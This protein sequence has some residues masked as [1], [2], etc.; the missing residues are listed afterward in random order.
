M[1][2]NSEEKIINLSSP[3]TDIKGVGP[4]KKES[5]NRLGINCL[6]D[7]L[8]LYP[9][10][11]EDLRNVKEIF[12]VQDDEKCLVRAA[13][14]MSRP[15]KGYG[16]K[17]TLHVLAEDRTGR[18]EVLFF[19]AGFMKFEIGTIYNFFGKCKV[20]NGRVT[21]FHP[22]YSKYEGEEGSILPVYPLTKGLTQ[23]DVR[24]LSKECFNHIDE[25]KETLPEEVVKEANLCSNSYALSNIHYPEDDEKYKQA[26]YRLVF[27]ELF[28]LKTALAISKSMATDDKKGFS[29]TGSF[30]KDFVNKLPYKLT[31]AQ[32]KVLADVLL[33]MK[34]KKPMNRL[35]QGD[36]GSGKTIIAEAAIVQAVLNGAQAAFMAPTEILASQHFETLKKDFEKLNINIDYIDGS[37]GAKERREALQRLES[38]ETNVVIGTHALISSSVTYKNL[39]LVIT[40][41]QHR[42]GVSQ[43]R[44]LSEKGN[45][46]DVIVM[47]ATPIPR[48]LAVVLYADLDISIIDEMPPGRIPIITKKFNKDNRKDAY[49]LLEEEINK[50]HQAYIVAPLIEES[51]AIEG[52]SAE[53][54][55]AE[56][57]KNYPNIKAKL[58]HGQMSDKEKDSIMSEF[59]S[60]DISVLIST[61][62]IEVGINVPN[63][64][65]MLIENQ[66]RFGLAQLHQLRGRVGRGKNQSYC[67]L[68][69][70]EE[71]EIAKERAKIMC[72]SSDGFVI[73]EKDLEMRGPGEFFG[74]RQHGLPQ[75]K[76]ADP[77]KHAKIAELAG[78]ASLKLLEKDP[79]LT[80]PNNKNFAAKLRNKYM[81]IDNITL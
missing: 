53:E 78:R 38:G 70:G 55:Y 25:L 63:A 46:P 9:R 27:E 60:G 67:L 50:G 23:K 42:F 1:K 51:D 68:V 32:N 57:T 74:Y 22:T 81:Q 12:D 80:S 62:V 45:N 3:I 8:D 33:D 75:L 72:E 17:R 36:V 6:G 2:E 41:E 15:G 77:I 48:T 16:R 47:T 73:A 69:S 5:F 76:F 44:M 10:S 34:S 11:Y 4:K 29:F 79:S 24:R 28:D 71:T 59:Y 64:S 52:E 19:M 35:I 56:F 49:K 13:V 61:V 43:R 18:M 37:L 39:G 7:C 58:L 26:R 65:V 66:E 31:N 30:A 54:L 40:D 20:E 14:V 21:M